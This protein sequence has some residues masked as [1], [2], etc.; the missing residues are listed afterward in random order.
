MK[1]KLTKNKKEGFGRTLYQIKALKNFGNIK[2]GDLG[3]WIEKKD[4]LSQK[5]NCWVRDNAWVCGNAWVYGNAQVRGNAWVRD[6][7]RVCGNAWVY[8]N[9]WVRDNARVC[10]N[11]WVYGNAR[12]CGELELIGGRFYHTKQ[13]SERIE[14]IEIDE[15]HE[16]LCSKPKLAKE[17]SE[18]PKTG[19]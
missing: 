2:K 18:E 5:D 19:N 15:D 9:A 4:N 3:G 8:G 12:V 7:A 10:G 14:K 13:K 17:E 1:Y 11:A 16:L 6:N